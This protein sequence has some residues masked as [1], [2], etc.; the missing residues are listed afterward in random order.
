M[1]DFRLQSALSTILTK[2]T[3]TENSVVSLQLNIDG[4]P[5]LKNLFTQFWPILCRIVCFFE[6]EPFV[7]GLHCGSSKPRDIF[8]YM[9]ELVSELKVLETGL[10][11]EGVILYACIWRFYS[12]MLCIRG[13]SHGPVSVSVCD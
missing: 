4:L 12:A 5:I 11:V 7:I 8:E 1:D 10:S 3:V 2:A 13:T 6:T 9:K